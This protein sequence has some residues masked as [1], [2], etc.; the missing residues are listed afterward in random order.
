LPGRRDLFKQAGT[1][2]SGNFQIGD[3]APGEY[4]IF[5]WEDVDMN[6]VQNAEFRKAMAGRGA[7]VSIAPNGRESVQLQRISAEDFEKE[8]NKLP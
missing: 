6:V 8:K 7:T 5:A 1:D 2:P 3:V 4:L